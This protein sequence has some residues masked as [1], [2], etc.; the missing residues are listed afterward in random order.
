[1]RILAIIGILHFPAGLITPSII[2]NDKL[3]LSFISNASCPF[4]HRNAATRASVYGPVD[5]L[6]GHLDS[7]KCR[8]QLRVTM[9]A[10]NQHNYS[11]S[12]NR[13]RIGYIQNTKVLY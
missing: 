5:A 13:T 7:H 3:I 6:T 8:K 12:S 9:Q 11:I 2:Y 4:H 10:H 1:M